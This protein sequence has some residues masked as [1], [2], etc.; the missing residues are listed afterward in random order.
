MHQLEKCSNPPQ[1]PGEAAPA[2]GNPLVFTQ[3]QPAVRLA[4]FLPACSIAPWLP[5]SRACGR[6]TPKSRKTSRPAPPCPLSSQ[7]EASPAIPL[8]LQCSEKKG[9]GYRLQGTGKTRSQKQG[10]RSQ[11]K[12]QIFR[13]VYPERS[14]GTQNDSEGLGMTT[15]AAPATVRRETV[16]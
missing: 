9:T 8:R 2:S 1:M 16:S 12:K 3:V 6:L 4:E 15:L 7:P 10:V 13:G 5:A 14:R 11:K